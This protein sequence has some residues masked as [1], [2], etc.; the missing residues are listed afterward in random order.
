MTRILLFVGMLLFGTVP[1]FAQVCG[2]ALSCPRQGGLPSLLVN[3]S[4]PSTFWVSPFPPSCPPPQVFMG[5]SNLPQTPALAHGT[6]YTFKT[7]A[8]PNQPRFAVACWGPLANA[9]CAYWNIYY[10]PL[11]CPLPPPTLGFCKQC[12]ANGGICTTGPGGKKYC[13]YQ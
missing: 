9:R 13:V 6:N 11:Y 3:C 4:T 8:D 2:G 1:C 12:V 5:C 10:S 7:T